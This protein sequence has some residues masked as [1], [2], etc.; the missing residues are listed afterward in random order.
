MQKSAD[1]YREKYEL[2]T[3]RIDDFKLAISYLAAL[4]RLHIIL[5]EPDNAEV[6]KKKADVW[7]AKMEA[8]E[9]KLSSTA[10]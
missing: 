6:V 9:K 1:R 7:K 2:S 10:G 5:G 3:S 4:R 8:D